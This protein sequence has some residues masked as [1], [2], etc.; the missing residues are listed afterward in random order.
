MFG[1][2]LLYLLYFSVLCFW[3]FVLLGVCAFGVLC[4]CVCIHQ[5]HLIYTSI[6]LSI[7]LSTVLCV[8]CFFCVLFFLC[9]VF[10]VFFSF[11]HVRLGPFPGRAGYVV[12]CDIK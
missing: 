1:F 7:D 8:L 12:V 5:L 2:G 9:F 4:F 10:C 6:Y 11:I 3:G